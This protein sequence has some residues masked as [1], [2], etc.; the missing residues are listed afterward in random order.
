MAKHIK[1]YFEKIDE[2]VGFGAVVLIKGKEKAGKKSLYATHV[3]GSAELHT[4]VTML[5]LSNDF[6]RITRQDGQLRSAKI[7]FLSEDALRSVLNLKTPGKIS[8][9]KNNN[10]TPWH[11]KTLKH[12]NLQS[13]LREIED[14]VDPVEYILESADSNMEERDQLW[15]E[16]YSMVVTETA[17]TA[18]FNIPEIDI[19]SHEVSDELKNAASDTSEESDSPVEWDIN[20]RVLCKNTKYEKYLQYFDMDPAV[21][22]TFMFNT[23]FEIHVDHDPGDYWTPPYT[24]IE[25]DTIGTETT[26]FFVDGG[27]P[28]ELPPPLKE[29]K[30]RLNSL[31][32]QLDDDGLDK[33]IKKNVQPQWFSKYIK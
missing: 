14:V 33:L 32:Y 4:G 7:A 16:F 23:E 19:L 3:I 9:V 20:F 21:D 17:N 12:A 27:S 31:V 5:F 2:S 6:Y 8:V 11:W 13:A 22:V 25:F 15:N 10:K 26:D 29:I 30:K 18:F 24:D 28:D 1:S